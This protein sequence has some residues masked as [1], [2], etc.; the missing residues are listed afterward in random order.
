MVAYTERTGEKVTYQSISDV[1]GLSRS[2]LEALGSRADYNTTLATVE[3]LCRFF[4]CG[5]AD[6][7]CLSKDKI[8]K[9]AD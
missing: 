6:L 7:L 3:A 8:E 9:H 4:D 2:T 1:T 5:V